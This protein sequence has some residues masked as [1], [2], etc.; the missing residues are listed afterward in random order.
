MVIWFLI[1]DYGLADSAT[2]EPRLV[3]LWSGIFIDSVEHSLVPCA[4]TDGDAWERAVR[5]CERRELVL[6]SYE[7]YHEAYAGGATRAERGHPRSPEPAQ[8]ARAYHE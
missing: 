1:S 5:A 7:E 2:D 8:H 6:C 3:Q 4:D